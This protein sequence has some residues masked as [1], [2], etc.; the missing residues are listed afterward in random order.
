MPYGQAGPTLIV[1]RVIEHRNHGHMDGPDRL[2]DAVQSVIQWCLSSPD[3]ERELIEQMHR[4]CPRPH[5]AIP[6]L[7]AGI[8]TINLAGGKKGENFIPEA[9]PSQPPLGQLFVFQRGI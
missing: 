5:F 3:L 2:G 4:T 9:F 6:A 1:E 8:G 7:G